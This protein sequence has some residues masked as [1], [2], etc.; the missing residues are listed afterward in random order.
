MN[1]WYE[2]FARPSLDKAR[3]TVMNA[4][5]AVWGSVSSN[6][7]VWLKSA[8]IAAAASGL[9]GLAPIFNAMGTG[10]E[11]VMQ[12]SRLDDYQKALE[13]EEAVKAAKKSGAGTTRPSTVEGEAWGGVPRESPSLTPEQKAVLH[14]GA[15]RRQT[16]IMMSG[17]QATSDAMAYQREKARQA[18]AQ[19]NQPLSDPRFRQAPGGQV[20]QAQRNPFAPPGMRGQKQRQGQGREQEAQPSQPSLATLAQQLVQRRPAGIFSQGA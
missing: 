4:P 19:L 1:E 12:R 10:A 18:R 20:L 17:A 16:D 6:P 8:G 3:E 14:R 13:A 5:G 9:P 11:G 2:G 15:P 7:D